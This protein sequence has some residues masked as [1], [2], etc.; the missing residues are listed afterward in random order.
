M[1]F[2]KINDKEANLIC[3]CTKCQKEV[4][5]KVQIN[6]FMDWRYGGR[7]IALAFDYLSPDEREILISGICSECFDKIFKKEES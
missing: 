4:T 3:V 1:E 7:H 5:L 6:D 2:R